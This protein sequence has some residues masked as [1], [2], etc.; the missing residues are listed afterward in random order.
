M[1]KENNIKPG[2]SKLKALHIMEVVLNWIRKNMRTYIYSY[3]D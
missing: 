1:D 3:N 2:N